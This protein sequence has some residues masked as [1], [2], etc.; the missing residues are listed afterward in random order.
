MWSLTHQDHTDC[1]FGIGKQELVEF[2]VVG[3]GQGV[4]THRLCHCRVVHPPVCPELLTWGTRHGLPGLSVQEIADKGK[5]QTLLERAL[6][7]RFQDQGSVGE[8]VAAV[9]APQSRLPEGWHWWIQKEGLGWGL[10]D[11]LLWGRTISL[12]L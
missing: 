3:R 5:L 11:Q 4:S 7:A 10:G 2:W 9:E 1:P 8:R 6:M 12:T